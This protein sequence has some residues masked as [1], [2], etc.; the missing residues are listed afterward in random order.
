MRQTLGTA[1]FSG[2]IGVTLFGLALTPVF[3]YSIDWLGDSRLFA[4][5]RVQWLGMVLLTVV[6]MLML[7]AFWWL[8]LLLGKLFRRSQAATPLG[9]GGPHSEGL[10]DVRI[11]ANGTVGD[12]GPDRVQWK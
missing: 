7:G 1:V 8:P 10:P 5:A 2:M 11:T 9:T 12:A 6:G 3:F 4:S